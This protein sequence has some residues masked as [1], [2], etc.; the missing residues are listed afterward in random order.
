MIA[1]FE[2]NGTITGAL[3]RFGVGDYTRRVTRVRAC[4]PTADEARLL[5]QPPVEP[6]LVTE[7]INTDAAGAPIEYGIAKF[8]AD[9][10][11][12]VFES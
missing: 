3:A 5:H 8:A 4:L 2:E 1:A 9:R 7:A 10:V 11:R 12:L 6:L